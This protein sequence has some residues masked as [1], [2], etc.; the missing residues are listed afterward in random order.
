MKLEKEEL[1][2]MAMLNNSVLI[3]PDRLSEDE[4]KT[5]SGIKLYL[6]TRFET[7]NHINVWGKVVKAPD[8]LFFKQG[9]EKSMVWDTDIEIQEGDYVMYDFVAAAQALGKLYD[10][11]FEGNDTKY[12]FCEDELYLVLQYQ[13]LILKKSGNDITMLNGYVLV[14]PTQETEVDSK[15]II[16]LDH[17][18]KK[19]S[20]RYGIVAHKGSLIREYLVLFSDQDVICD[21]TDVEVGDKIVFDKYA[22]IACEVELHQKLNKKFF[23]MQR[24]EILAILR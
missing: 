15:K 4:L 17:I 13:H 3:K 21:N 12:I 19:D 22:D 10:K 8:K 20:L 2:R 9:S 7:A 1:V 18:K 24:K 6:D 5:H 11:N 16:L 14:E 23:R